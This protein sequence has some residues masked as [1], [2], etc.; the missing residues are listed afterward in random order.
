MRHRLLLSVVDLCLIGIATL[1][2][3][4]LR[5]SFDTSLA[6]VV[7]LLPY[8]GLTLAAAIP[9]MAVFGLNQSIW[10]LSGMPDYLSVLGAAIVIV[11]AAVGLGFLFNRLEGVARSLPI[12]QAYLIVFGLVGARVVARLRH[13]GREKALAVP[14]KA[15]SGPE[16]IL[17]V[18]INPIT[19]LYLRSVAELAAGRVEVM[20]LV[21]RK[22]SQTGR[23]VQRHRILGTVERIASILM[24]QEV[25]GVTINRIVV[26]LPFEDLSP[27]A[28]AALL[29]VEE[30]SG[31]RVEFFAEQICGPQ[32][33]DRP[34]LASP[35]APS[36]PASGPDA[37]LPIAGKGQDEPTQRSYWRVKRALDIAAAACGI[38]LLAPLLLLISVLVMVEIGPPAIFWQQRTGVGGRPFRLY[39]LRTMALP[40]DADGRRIADADRLSSIGRFLR[41][42][43]LDELPQLFNILIGEM[44][45]VGPRP[46]LRADQFPGLDAQFSVRP[47]IT[48]WAQVKGGRKLTAPDK[49]ALDVWY[50]RNASLRVDLQILMGTLRVVLLGERTADGIAIREAWRE[51]RSAPPREE[52]R[53]EAK[54]K[55]RDKWGAA[56]APETVPAQTSA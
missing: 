25:H 6:Q 35:L 52:A 37:V 14:A 56:A 47:G 8:L 42:F 29:E 26:T 39:K 19:E 51:L 3:Q 27:G 10:R 38:V 44:S 15:D 12:I 17:V 43:R 53:G 49:A 36:L 48:G 13:I 18:G 11:T 55:S 24:D 4:L 16:H 34:A 46:L 45:F 9:A 1:C 21:A 32:Q 54:D 5:D 20:G 28:R 23:L 2:A 22:E 33:A 40:Y 31:V 7:V 41:R 30:S 50:I